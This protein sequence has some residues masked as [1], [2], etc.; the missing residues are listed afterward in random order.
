MKFSGNG[1]K[2]KSVFL[3]NGKSL[4]NVPKYKYLGIEL[5]LPVH[6]VVQLQI[7][8]IWERRRCFYLKAI[9]VQEL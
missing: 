1:H 7:Y 9:H 3:Y 4:E 8:Q 2:C 5:V 6:G